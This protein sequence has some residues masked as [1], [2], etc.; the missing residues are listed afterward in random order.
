M[1]RQSAKVVLVW[2]LVVVGMF[3]AGWLAV[4]LASPPS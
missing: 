4:M 3:L 2:M 1:T